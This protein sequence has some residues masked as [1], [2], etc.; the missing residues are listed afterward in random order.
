MP[1]ASRRMTK[2]FRQRMLMD[3]AFFFLGITAVMLILLRVLDHKQF[4]IAALVLIPLAA[5]A[6]NIRQ[7]RAFAAENAAGKR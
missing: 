6:F 4:F 7:R 2:A 1:S 5:M 3:A